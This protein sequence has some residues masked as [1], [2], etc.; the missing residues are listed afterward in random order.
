MEAG[1][2]EE[3]RC[4]DDNKIINKN[5][6]AGDANCKILATGWDRERQR[7]REAFVYEEIVQINK[8]PGALKEEGKSWVVII[9]YKQRVTLPQKG[10]TLS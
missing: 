1:R 4:V 3:T 10:R 9:K 5:A 6:S 2:Q 7:E 8:I